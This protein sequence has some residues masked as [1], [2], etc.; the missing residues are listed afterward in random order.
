MSALMHIASPS[1]CKAPSLSYGW[2]AADDAAASHRKGGE[3]EGQG[4]G[5]AGRAGAAGGSQFSVSGSDGTWEAAAAGPAARG[6]G[7]EEELAGYEVA[8]RKV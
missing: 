3:R 8:L 5:G 4:E 2:N 7:Q 1:A 6:R